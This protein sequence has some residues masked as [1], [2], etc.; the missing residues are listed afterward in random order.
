MASPLVAKGVQ[1]IEG[2]YVQKWLC[3]LRQ[4]NGVATMATPFWF[5]AELT[6]N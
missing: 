6:T 5:L 4:K 2:Y 3:E 1:S